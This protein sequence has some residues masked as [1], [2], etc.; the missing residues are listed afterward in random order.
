MHL[1]K[2]RT[3]INALTGNMIRG[4]RDMKKLFIIMVVLGI[5]STANAGKEANGW[6]FEG[7]GESGNNA[8]QID[9]IGY[10]QGVLQIKFVDCPG[11]DPTLGGFNFASSLTADETVHKSII[12]MLTTAQ[13]SGKRV[14]AHANANDE[15]DVIYVF[16]DRTYD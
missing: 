2:T 8:L 4:G 14:R 16:T 3:C 7:D 15:I 5:A 1:R 9:C 6:L 11:S 10:V 13:M 12:A